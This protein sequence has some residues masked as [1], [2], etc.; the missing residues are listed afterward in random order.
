MSPTQARDGLQR[1]SLLDTRLANHCPKIP[2]CQ[3]NYKYR[4]IDGNCNN[5]RNPFWGKSLTQFTRLLPPQYADGINQFRMSVD[6]APLPGPRE[7]SNMASIYKIIFV[8]NL[9][10]HKIN[11]KNIDQM[12]LHLTEWKVFYSF[13]LPK[14]QSCCY[15]DHWKINWFI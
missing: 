6:G 5:L 14:N 15:Y 3:P 2:R 7:L 11:E 12:Y 9:I 8:F 4:T 10:C 1:Y 13:F